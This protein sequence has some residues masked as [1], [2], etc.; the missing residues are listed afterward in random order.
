MPRTADDVA[1][2]AAPTDRPPPAPADA[3]PGERPEDGFGR[4]LRQLRVERGMTQAQ[5]AG[6]TITSGLVSLLETGRR[7]PSLRTVEYLARRLGCAPSDLMATAGPEPEAIAALDLYR[8]E[9]ALRSGAPAAA[10]ERFEAL[11]D[12]PSGERAWR[13]ALGRAQALEALGRVAEAAEQLERLR[14][15]APSD[16]AVGFSAATSLACCHLRT[17]RLRSG[18][19]LLTALYDQMDAVGWAGTGDHARVVTALIELAV[20]QRRPAD[21]AELAGRH[22]GDPLPAPRPDHAR[23]LGERSARA[24]AAGRIADATVLAERAAAAWAD[25][26]DVRVGARL[27]LVAAMACATPA[28]APLE[29][30]VAEVGA[31]RAAFAGGGSATDVSACDRALGVLTRRQQAASGDAPPAP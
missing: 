1:D 5:L 19:E 25:E 28:D 23:A 2:H 18:E 21:A 7:G 15:A 6:T 4:R 13:V 10:L 11:G 20:A 24:E 26:V 14:A 22:L 12:G 27:K 31:A 30:L 8:A 29:R 17:L 3:A 9:V 16:A